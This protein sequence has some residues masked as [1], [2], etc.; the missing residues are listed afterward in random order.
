MKH[1]I[2][3]ILAEAALETIPD[4]LWTHPAVKA[5][6][7]RKNKPA[8]QILLDTALH[9]HA[10]R[11]LPE[12]QKRG[13]P[14]I[15][16]VCLLLATA[17]P[18][19]RENMLNILIHTRNGQLIQVNPGLQWRPPKNYNRFCGLIEQLFASPKK[20]LISEISSPS[21]LGQKKY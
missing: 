14:D 5:S 13:R 21:N 3:L 8:D 11:S 17:S 15:T 4:S 2:T 1:P 20:S 10:M 6:V 9:H 7:T 19:Y 18:L 16:H 12:H